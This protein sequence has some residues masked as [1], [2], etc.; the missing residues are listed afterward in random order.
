MSGFGTYPNLYS[1]SS[2]PQLTLEDA[3]AYQSPR[4]VGAF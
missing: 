1:K 3:A 2:L 4:P